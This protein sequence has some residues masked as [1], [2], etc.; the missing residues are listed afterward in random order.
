MAISAIYHT[1]YTRSV[2][3]GLFYLLISYDFPST[4]VG[5][6]QRSC[7]GSTNVWFLGALVI[8]I[9][10]QLQQMPVIKQ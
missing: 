4:M 6:S 8:L 2:G 5:A 7:I 1:K 10:Q 3:E 9:K